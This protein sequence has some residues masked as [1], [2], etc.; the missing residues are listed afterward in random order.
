MPR[1]SKPDN[2]PR[3]DAAAHSTPADIASCSFTEAQWAAMADVR[4]RARDR[5]AR[6]FSADPT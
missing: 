4:R 2:A 1:K 3:Y 6:A 5:I